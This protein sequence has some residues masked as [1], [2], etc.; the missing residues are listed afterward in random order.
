[1]KKERHFVANLKKGD[2]L[3]KGTEKGEK[4]VLDRRQGDSTW[5]R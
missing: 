5:G 3:F 4:K 1:M 2:F